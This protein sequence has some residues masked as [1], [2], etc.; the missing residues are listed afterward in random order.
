[1]FNPPRLCMFCV[2]LTSY[3]FF[4]CTLRLGRLHFHALFT[5]QLRGFGHFLAGCGMEVGAHNCQNCNTSCKYQGIVQWNV[6]ITRKLCFTGK[7]SVGNLEKSWNRIA[8]EE[9]KCFDEYCGLRILFTKQAKLKNL[10]FCKEN[11]FKKTGS[12][13]SSCRSLWHFSGEEHWNGG[14]WGH[15]Q[16][17]WPRKWHWVTCQT[18]PL[19]ADLNK[20]NCLDF[21][22]N[23]L[24]CG[25][26]AGV[27]VCR[28][29]LYVF[30]KRDGTWHWCDV[31]KEMVG[32]GRLFRS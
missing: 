11:N 16:R 6:F 9:P 23:H 4:G 10:H 18:D 5:S 21:I 25:I 7:E 31:K 14:G 8:Q 20:Q 32:F 1:M 30:G 24:W 2:S 15:W 26:F 12:S 13:C 19:V 27:K 22:D 28:T 17:L 3:R 29:K